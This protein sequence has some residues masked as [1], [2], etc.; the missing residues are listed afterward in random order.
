MKIIVNGVFTFLLVSSSGGALA[1]KPNTTH[2]DLTGVAV[3]KSALLT[4]PALLPNLGLLPFSQ[5][6]LFSSKTITNLFQIGVVEEDDGTRG[7]NHFYDP[8]KNR[9][10]TVFGFVSPGK[11]SPDWALEDTGDIAE[12]LFS[13]KDARD[14]FYRALTTNNPAFSSDVNEIIRKGYW[15]SVFGNLG[16]TIHHIQD[17]AQPQHVRNDQHCDL[18]FLGCFGIFDNL[19]R[20]EVYSGNE[21][22]KRIDALASS[23]QTIAAFPDSPVFKTP[24]DFWKNAAGTGIAEFTNQNFVSQGT[25]FTSFLGVVG[26]SKYP[27]PLPGTP[28]N[29]KIDDLYAA[30]GATVPT[31]IQSLCTGVGVNCRMTM[32]PTQLTAKAS[33]LSFRSRLA[34]Q[35]RTCNLR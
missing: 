27:F 13:Y 25:N 19:S 1:Y 5:N 29:Y 31:G 32:Y 30:Q 20:Y 12:Q 3:S 4:D 17:M 8:Y 23:P 9:A 18:G 24:R 22:R 7:L 28:T 11:K 14:F 35:G 34:S 2:S 26:T 6:Q 10:L 15:S 16:H 21:S 33:T